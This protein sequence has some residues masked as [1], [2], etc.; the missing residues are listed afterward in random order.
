MFLKYKNTQTSSALSLHSA[1]Q[2]WR[3]SYKYT[4]KL[5]CNSINVYCISARKCR[6]MKSGGIQADLTSWC[7][8]GDYKVTRN[9]NAA[10]NFLC[11]LN[12]CDA[13]A[14]SLPHVGREGRRQKC[15][16]H[17]LLIS[18]LVTDVDISEISKSVQMV[19]HQIHCKKFAE[20][21]KDTN[22]CMCLVLCT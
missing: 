21:L 10:E 9:G 12:I 22:L 13:V 2:Y 3:E 17:S 15:Q 11:N 19:L 8:Y 6:C 18:S 14:W 16:G 1:L 4:Q 5:L 20:F 7:C